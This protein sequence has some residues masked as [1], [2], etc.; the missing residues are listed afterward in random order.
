MVRI[1]GAAYLMGNPIMTEIDRGYREAERPQRSVVVKEFWLARALVTAE[2]FCLF[3]NEVG[4]DGFFIENTGRFDWRTIE[5]VGETYS[6]DY[7]KNGRKGVPRNPGD[8]YV[9][10]YGAERSPAAPVT[11]AGA[12]AYC[13]WLSLRLGHEFRL[14]TEAEWELAARGP[15]LRAWP[16]GNEGPLRVDNTNTGP[17]GNQVP[18]FMQ[19]GQRWSRWPWEQRPPWPGEPVCSFPRNATPDGVCDMMGYH[20]GQWCS[21][22]AHGE[23]ARMPGAPEPMY[24]TRGRSIVVVGYDKPPTSVPLRLVLKLLFG[25]ES[26]QESDTIEGRSWSRVGENMSHGAMFRVASSSA[27]GGQ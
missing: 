4:N 22:R 24:V 23:I 7:P 27:P 15:E 17:D 16:W 2:E 20:D 8:R 25:L 14:P 18:F 10:H 12:A 21:D 26:G 5:V 6:P 9:P 1:P 19:F 3:L 13:K 11:W